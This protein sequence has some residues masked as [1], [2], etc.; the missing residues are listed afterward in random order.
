MRWLKP[1]LQQV[2]PYH[3][4]HKD[5]LIKLDAN[6]SEHFLFQ[7]GIVFEEALHRY[8]DNH[9]TALKDKLAHTLGINNNQ[10]L[11]GAGSSDVID[12]VIKS[13]VAPGETILTFSPT[14]VMYQFYAKMHNAV[15]I[16]VPLEE[17]YT[18]NLERFLSAV[19]K[20]QPKL[21]ILCSPNN[22]TGTI[23]PDDV[24]QTI[25]EQAPGLVILDQAYVEFSNTTRNWLDAIESYPHLLLTRTFSKAY[26]LAGLRLGYGIGSAS[27]IE[28]LTRTI[29]PYHLSSFTQ[30]VGRL[31]LDHYDEMRQFT[32]A[33][34]ERKETLATQLKDLGF[35]VYPSGGN[36]LFVKSP[37][38]ELSKRLEA[39]GILIRGFPGTPPT[40]RITVGTHAD[41]HL[42]LQA[43][44][45]LTNELME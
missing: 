43:I 36:F 12:H 28:E 32:T 8:P 22:P 18:L 1:S 27:L 25:V 9:A 24:I 15:M 29:I 3:A 17:D 35:T 34:M 45:E 19:Q 39:K 7:T 4:V 37:I 13:T 31:A 14:F 20:H 6:E 2:P 30:A 33:V 41:H 23:V 10:C 16:E 5:Y 21:I 11:L 44:K 40:Y 38:D 42:L 26:G